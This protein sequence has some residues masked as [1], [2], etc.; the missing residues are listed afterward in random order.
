MC[1]H[2]YREE[3]RMKERQG[4]SILSSGPQ[5]ERGCRGMLCTWAEEEE[6]SPFLFLSL[7]FYPFFFSASP[8]FLLPSHTS[9][10]IPS[11]HVLLRHPPPHPST[12]LFP[13]PLLFCIRLD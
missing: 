8:Q 6:K 9:F 11:A 12:I 4:I 10:S 2:T 3:K 7:P 1:H 5:S 13:P